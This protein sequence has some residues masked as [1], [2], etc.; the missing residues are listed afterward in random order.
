ME[1][2]F[3][4]KK[5]SELTRDLGFN[6][7]YYPEEGSKYNPPK[8]Q[9]FCAITS[10]SK[11]TDRNWEDVYRELTELGI[12]NRIEAVEEPNIIAF[13]DDNCKYKIRK[14]SN[15][16]LYFLKNEK[17]KDKKY[18]IM[19]SGHMFLMD[20][21]TI[22]DFKYNNID[23]NM[24][25]AGSI[26]EIIDNENEKDIKDKKSA[27]SIINYLPIKDRF[28]RYNPRM[29]KSNSNKSLGDSI[30]RALC[31]TDNQKYHIVHFRL[32]YIELINERL[33][34]Y[35]AIKSMLET[36]YHYNQIL[37]DD[38]E[39]YSFYNFMKEYTKG[40]YII[41]LDIS[42]MCYQSKLYLPVIDGNVYYNDLITLGYLLN[43]TVI[44][45]YKK[46]EEN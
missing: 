8:S 13:L 46:E 24:C 2:D 33:F 12:K 34:D 4:F 26:I 41:V 31:K 10:L 17:Y 16:S 25:S 44:E 36:N 6:V 15:I 32:G 21:N 42:D 29:N 3:N 39:L 18:V 27:G 22:Y 23:Q 14:V 19:K 11:L 1:R 45:I 35:A 37:D 43:S 28:K 20:R 5:L 9:A 30:I 7:E 38:D 40:K